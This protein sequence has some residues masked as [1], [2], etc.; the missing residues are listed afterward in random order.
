[1][2][3]LLGGSWFS[4]WLLGDSLQLLGTSERSLCGTGVALLGNSA[5]PQLTCNREFT[6]A[7][8][9]TLHKTSQST[10]TQHCNSSSSHLHT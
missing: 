2:S 7:L 1:M 8:A 3:L 5:R 6:S 9:T 10:Y 4:V